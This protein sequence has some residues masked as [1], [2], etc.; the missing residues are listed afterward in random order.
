MRRCKKEVK[1]FKSAVIAVVGSK[2]SGKTATTEVIIRGLT[3]RGYKV[4]AVKHIPHKEFTIDTAHK[5]TWRFAKSGAVT[6]V[7]L[8]PKEIAT[9]EKTDTSN[10]SLNEILKKCRENDFVVIEGFRKLLGKNKAIP[11]I[12]AVKSAGEALEASKIFKPIIAFTG[13]YPTGELA[14]DV[15]YINVLREEEKIVD[16]IEKTFKKLEV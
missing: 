11:K 4:A 13:P 10:I 14:L 3:K 1:K 7:S 15:P 8:A 5:D 6:I 16:V 9:I 2:N 12:V